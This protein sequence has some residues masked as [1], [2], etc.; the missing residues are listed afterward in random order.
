VIAFIVTMAVLLPIAWCESRWDPEAQNKVSTAAGLFQIVEGTWDD[1]RRLGS[2]T[3]DFRTGRYRA[4]ENWQAAITL[5]RH[6]GTRPWG[7]SRE[8]V[9]RL[10]SAREAP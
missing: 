3:S 4:G 2:E 6:Y 9:L 8:C 7:A 5:Y 10:R 1:A